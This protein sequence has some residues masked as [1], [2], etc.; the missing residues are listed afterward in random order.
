MNAAF[1]I[2]ILTHSTNPRGGVVHALELGDALPRLGHDVMV[3]AP[4]A[5]G[6]GF[7]RKTLCRTASVAATPTGHNITAMVEARVRD[8]LRHFERPENRRFDVWHAQDGISANA[9]ATLKERGLIAGFARTVHH[10]DSFTDPRLMALQTRGI[11]AADTLFAVSRLWR[12][13]LAQRFDC[14]PA[15]IGNGV[16]TDRFSPMVDDTDDTL[17]A[18][19]RLQHGDVLFLSVGGVEARKNTVRILDAFARVHA[20]QPRARLVIAGGASI[21]DHDAYRAQFTRALASSGLPAG[22]VIETGPLPQE[23]MPAL[24]RAA[25]ALIFPSVSEGFG[26]V[27]LEAMASG[28]PVI[29][30]GIAPF[31]EYLGDADALWCDPLDAA[32]I[33]AAMMASL[34]SARPRALAGRGFAVAARHGWK[35]VAQAHLAPYRALREP[36]HA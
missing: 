2:A 32:S 22:A 11:A 12:D 19:L 6:A 13:W 24:Y 30:S 18:K 10:V 25:H 5:S 34:D 36:V 31:T 33:A 9:L 21:L 4:D 16:D 20:E 17:R 14:S 15:L 26:L 28:V 23:L 29:V 27:V 35:S 1:R 7:F 3:H 8:Y